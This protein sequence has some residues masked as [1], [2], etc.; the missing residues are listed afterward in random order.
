M[1]IENSNSIKL[2]I[3]LNEHIVSIVF[4]L[5]LLYF[6]ANVNIVAIIHIEKTEDHIPKFK[7]VCTSY[8]INNAIIFSN[9]PLTVI[10]FKNS[11]INS[12]FIEIDYFSKCHYFIA[13]LIL[14]VKQFI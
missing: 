7:S 8:I 6:L 10:P 13:L 3:V 5:F 14:I 9:T 1:F 12:F 4:E 2:V 11:I